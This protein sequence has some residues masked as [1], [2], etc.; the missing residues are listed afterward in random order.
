M[1]TNV[2]MEYKAKLIAINKKIREI[3]KLNL[4]V[5]EYKEKLRN[6]T[7]DVETK[8]K[9][10]KKQNFEGFLISDYT[11]GIQKLTELEYKLA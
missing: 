11:S 4:N 10:S 5:E 6:I 1:N 9:S 8:I 3:E 2:A 7:N